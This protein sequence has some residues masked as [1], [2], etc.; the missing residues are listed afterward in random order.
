MRCGDISLFL[1]IQQSVSGW[2]LRRRSL[3]IALEQ[4]LLGDSMGQA[5]QVMDSLL[6]AQ[7]FKSKFNVLK[8]S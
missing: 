8:P 3:L 5:I 1:A 6:G 4:Q 2:N 7:L